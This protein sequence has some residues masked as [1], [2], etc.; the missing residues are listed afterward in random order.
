MDPAG[1]RSGR[2]KNRPG[3]GSSVLQIKTKAHFKLS[4][5]ATSRLEFLEDEKVTFTYITKEDEEK[6]NAEPGDHEGIVELGRDIEGVEVAIL[7]RETDEG[8]KASLRSNG[9]INVSD[10]C[11]MFGGGGHPAAAGC[12]LSYSLE[13]AKQKIIAQVKANLH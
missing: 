4:Q 6:V 13:D 3:N 8:F 7:L 12:T 11:M 10:I 9:N 1:F 2:N 5:M